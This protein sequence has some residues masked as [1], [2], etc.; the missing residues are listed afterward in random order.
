MRAKGSQLW[1]NNME[2]VDKTLEDLKA[3]GYTEDKIYDVI[4]DKIREALNVP[5][6]GKYDFA[7]TGSLAN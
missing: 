3:A 4:R 2:H 6:V 5:M 7:R 1:S